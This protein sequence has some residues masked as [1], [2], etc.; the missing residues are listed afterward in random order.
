MLKGIT[1][2]DIWREKKKELS[3]LGGKAI[4]FALTSLL[5]GGTGVLFMKSSLRNRPLSLPN[6]VQLRLLRQPRF[7]LAL[8]CYSPLG[9]T[10]VMSGLWAKT[11][12]DR[13]N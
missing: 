2:R 4:I 7:T 3:S 11:L 1:K 10:L 6:P 12:T 5:V 8:V 13:S 9:R